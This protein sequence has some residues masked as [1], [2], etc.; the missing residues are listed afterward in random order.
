MTKKIGTGKVKSTQAVD[1]AEKAKGVKKATKTGAAS[2]VKADLTITSA[3][4][5]DMKRRAQEEADKVLKDSNLTD[6]QKKILK[7]ALDMTIDG[8]AVD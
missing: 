5:E 2:A 3:N 8:A 1:R 4:K 7:R 6:K